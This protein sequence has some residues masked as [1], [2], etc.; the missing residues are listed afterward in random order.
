[1]LV[2]S[3]ARC[4][5][6]MAAI[7]ASVTRFP[8]LPAFWRSSSTLST[9]SGPPPTSVTCGCVNTRARARPPLRRSSVRRT[10]ARSSPA[11]RSRRRPRAEANWLDTV[12]TTP[13]TNGRR[14]CA[15]TT[16]IVRVQQQIRVGNE[17]ARRR[18]SGGMPR[19]PTPRACGSTRRDRVRDAGQSVV[20]GRGRLA[21]VAS[22]ARRQASRTARFNTSLKLLPDRRIALRR[23]DSTSGSRVTVVRLGHA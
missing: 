19:P 9:W 14:R 22:A 15:R 1:M 16:P 5:S 8:A 3:R 7:W 10:R 17:H 20:P 13:S 23:S 4:S 12:P 2:Q 18:P 6:A 11:V 21:F